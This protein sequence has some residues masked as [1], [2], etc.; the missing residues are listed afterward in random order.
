M[1]NKIALIFLMI[2]S[3]TLSMSAVG[4]NLPPGLL[5]IEDIVKQFR[6]PF[7]T[8]MKQMTKSVKC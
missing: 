3:P 7:E 8:K 1:L 4:E 5:S 6:A 2:T